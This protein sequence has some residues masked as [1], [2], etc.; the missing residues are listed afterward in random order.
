M[1]EERVKYAR[2]LGETERRL[3]AL[4]AWRESP[5]FT[6]REPAALEWTEALTVISKNDVPHSL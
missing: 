4:C 3:Y 6:G 1:M 2:K 5:F